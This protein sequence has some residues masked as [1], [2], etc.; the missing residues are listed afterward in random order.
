MTN[1]L[2]LSLKL[3]TKISDS[4]GFILLA[5]GILI[6]SLAAIFIRISENE[7]GLFATIFNR[8]WIGFITLF[9]W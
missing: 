8:L 2:E 1:K 4:I 9:V 6:L 5:I 3:K 7:L